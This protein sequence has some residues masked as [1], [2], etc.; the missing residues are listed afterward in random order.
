M[1]AFLFQEVQEVFVACGSKFGKTIGASVALTNGVMNKTGARWR[2]IA[3]IYRQALIGMSYFKGIIPPPPHS[4][5]IESKMIIRFPYIKSEIEFWHT[6]NP[7][8][9]EGAGIHGQIGDEAAKMP[10][11]AYVSAK[12][13]TTF[14]RGPSMWIST[15][16]G[17]NWFYKKYTEAKAEMEWA[18]RNGR[19]PRQLAIH[20]PTTDNPFVSK[21]V[22][23]QAR[24]DLP[25]RL[26]RQ[27]YLAE[28]IDEGSVFLGYRE[29]VDQSLPEIEKSARTVWFHPDAKSKA[30]V[31]GADW[32]KHKDFTV[33]FAIDYESKPRRCVGVMKFHGLAY[34]QAVKELYHFAKNFRTVAIAWHDKT[35]VG[36][37]IDDFLAPIPIP[38]HGVTLT[39]SIKSNLVNTLG[40]TFE[41]KDIVLPNWPDMLQ[42]LDV[43]EVEVSETGLMRYNAASGNHD[44]IVM[45]MAL[46]NSAAEEFMGSSYDIRFIEDLKED[47]SILTLDRYYKDL[48][49]DEDDEA[50][51]FGIK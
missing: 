23:E 25:D 2:W 32:A 38:F 6:Q 43:F 42:E 27:Y 44:D 12:T 7:V 11:D 15:P 3:P 20:A 37:A 45:A 33:F 39:N 14:T 18:I 50:A 16:Y 30:V 17:K 1:R 8:D 5:T 36:D 47:K 35:G 48:I 29:C 13:T 4:E 9:L 49:E 28:F 21:E 40:L 31:I 26:F 46:A 19:S 24:R 41:K 34:T 22:I 10:Y 51:L